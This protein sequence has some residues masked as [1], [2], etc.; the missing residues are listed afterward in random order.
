M[1]SERVSY[2]L[3]WAMVG[4]SGLGM[5]LHYAGRQSGALPRSARGFSDYP[6]PQP[7]PRRPP[8]V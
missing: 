5:Y 1:V 7:T 4:A 3:L 2:V 6:P 8:S